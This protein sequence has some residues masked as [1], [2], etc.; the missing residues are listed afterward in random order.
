MAKKTVEKNHS[1]TDQDVDDPIKNGGDSYT[2]E[3]VEREN[4]SKRENLRIKLVKGRPLR[5]GER[6][7]QKVIRY[8]WRQK[9]LKGF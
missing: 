9:R 7:I 4:S 6:Y 2:A 8:M 5:A 3:D 1:T